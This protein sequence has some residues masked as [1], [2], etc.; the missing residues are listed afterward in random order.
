MH[1]EKLVLM[2]QVSRKV[3]TR[4]LSYANKCLEAYLFHENVTTG[5]LVSIHLTNVG[6]DAASPTRAYLVASFSAVLELKDTGAF[7]YS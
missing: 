3:M 7:V 5:G 6:A 4:E 2:L 1:I